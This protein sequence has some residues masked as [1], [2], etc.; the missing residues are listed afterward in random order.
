[1]PELNLL[2]TTQ[3]TGSLREAILRAPLQ[4]LTAGPR[5]PEIAGL[6]KDRSTWT[7]MVDCKNPQ[8]LSV[9][10]AALWLVAGDLDRSHDISQ[11]NSSSEGSFWH[12]VMHRR[13][14]DFGNASYWFRRVGKHPVYSKLGAAVREEAFL[15]EAFLG[16]E[17]S[18]NPYEFVDRCAEVVNRSKGELKEQCILAQWL[19]WQVMVG[20][21]LDGRILDDGRD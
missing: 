6:L 8:R 10:E 4:G 13:E 3:I 20:H 7:P 11:D 18:W 19:E 12:G 16:P 2:D 14:G 5:V 17:N 21:I 15:G 1:M 9:I